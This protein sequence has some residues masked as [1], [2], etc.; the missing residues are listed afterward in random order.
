[1]QNEMFITVL[2]Y[3]SEACNM[4]G[5]RPKYTRCIENFPKMYDQ[6]KL[7]RSEEKTDVSVINKLWMEMLIWYAHEERLN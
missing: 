3:C 2:V 4:V 7:M 1:M 5:Y 6:S